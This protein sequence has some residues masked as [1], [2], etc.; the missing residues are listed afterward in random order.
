MPT[1]A[2]EMNGSSG[3]AIAPPP[4]DLSNTSDA[5]NAMRKLLGSTVIC[6]LDDGRELEG[7]FQCLDRLRNFILSDV[8]ET[9]RV[10]LADYGAYLESLD[11][12]N[13]EAVKKWQAESGQSSDV[14]ADGNVLVMRKLSQA[15]APGSRLKKVEVT[16]T[17]WEKSQSI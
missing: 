11:P 15:C 13:T 2:T 16:R 14:D 8:T 1:S 12:P 10:P 4:A 3:G 9:R 5:S 17:A 7:T 6:T